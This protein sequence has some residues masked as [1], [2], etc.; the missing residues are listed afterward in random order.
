MEEGQKVPKEGFVYLLKQ[1]NDDCCRW[2]WWQQVIS[3]LQRQDKHTPPVLSSPPSNPH[4]ISHN[5]SFSKFDLCL[6]DM[7]QMMLL[8]AVGIIQR[9]PLDGAVIGTFKYCSVCS[10]WTPFVF[11]GNY[12]VRLIIANIAQCLQYNIDIELKKY[13]LLCFWACNSTYII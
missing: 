4:N 7:P 2:I 10:D 12:L 9:L 11:W 5:V 1:D 13:L 3:S 8:P 6:W